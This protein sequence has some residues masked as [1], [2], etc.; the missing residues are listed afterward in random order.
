MR[1]F[2]PLPSGLTRPFTALVFLAWL[3]QMG[4]L[5]QASL[6][7]SPVALAADLARYGGSAQWKGVYYRGE[8]IG[9]AVGQTTATADGYEL[10]EEG[11]LQMNLLGATTVARLTTVAQVDREF[12]L[13]SF[14]FALD[15]GTGPTEIA[16]TVVGRRLDLSIRTSRGERTESHELEAPP[17]LQLNLSRQLAAQGLHE[18]QHI[19]TQVFDPA[20]MKNA[21]LDQTVE[22]REVVQVAGLPVPAFKVVSRFANINSA[23]W[24]TDVGEVVREESPMGLVVVKETPEFAQSLAVPG[25]VQQ[26]ML[27]A[28]AIVPK[29]PRRIDDPRA[30]RRLRMRVTGIEGFDPVEL[31]GAGQSLEGNEI[32]VRDARTLEL[33]LLD[34]DRGRYLGPEAFLESDAPEIR[35]EAERAVAEVK[36]PRARAER[37]VRHV[38]AIIEKKPTVSLPSALEVLR[39]R[40][41]D[42]NEHTALFVALARALDIPA[43]VAVGLVHLH[44]AFYY[45]AW[46]EVYLEENGRGL[47]LPVDP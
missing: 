42:C 11:R 37:L 21:P 17:T 16:G 45:H 8:K 46:A 4:L 36:G 28:A 23:S 24:I 9:F 7:G 25:R 12:A 3:V 41:G 44:G 35:A 2:R 1:I 31:N 33:G 38:N 29:P 13:R 30:V 15:P 19:V 39:T 40:V 18:G 34:A 5:V 26:D 6:R 22:R 43:R 27:E 20:T 32:E 10:R 14:S 47:W